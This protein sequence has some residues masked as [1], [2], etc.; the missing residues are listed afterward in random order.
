MLEHLESSGGRLEFGPELPDLIANLKISLYPLLYQNEAAAGN[1]LAN[2]FLGA[3]GAQAAEVELLE[4]TP[5]ERG[6]AVIELGEGLD[7]LDEVFNFRASDEKRAAA[8]V[9]YQ[10][11]DPEQQAASVAFIQ[12]VLGA[13]LVIF[14]E[15]LSVMVHGQKLTLLVQRALAGDD[16]AFLKAIQIDKRVLSTIPY[17]IE[18][19]NRASMR[20]EEA[21]VSAIAGKLKAPPYAGRLTHKKLWMTFAFL[22][23]MDLLDTYGG[24]ELLDLCIEVGSLDDGKP[25]EDVKNF[26]KLKSRYRA[27]QRSSGLS[28]P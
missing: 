20:N 7:A 6:Q 12:K 5:E 16:E 14:Y 21:F 24:N 9:A 11:L 27:F 28:T 15:H 17:F 13:V 1:L 25:M 10:A 18:R 4:A 22:D 3:D 19:F 8:L 2:A 23:S 26:L